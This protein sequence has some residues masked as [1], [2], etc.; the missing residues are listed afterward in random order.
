MHTVSHRGEKKDSNME[1]LG[2]TAVAFPIN[3]GGVLSEEAAC[4]LRLE[5]VRAPVNRVS[6]G[7]RNYRCKAPF[8][9]WTGHFLSQLEPSVRGPS[10]G[11]PQL[12]M[13]SAAQM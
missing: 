8:Q 10:R 11:S 12:G 3:R 4:E 7:R 6:E 2:G 5:E 9:E 13:V 1:G